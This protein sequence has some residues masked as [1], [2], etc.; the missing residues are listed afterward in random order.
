MFVRDFLSQLVHFPRHLP[1][2]LKEVSAKSKLVNQISFEN[3]HLCLI[4]DSLTPSIEQNTLTC[5]ELL[6]LLNMS[7]QLLGD[8]STIRG[9]II[10]TTF[11]PIYPRGFENSTYLFE[12]PQRSHINIL[13]PI[14]VIKCL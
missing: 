13:K 9:V 4:S 6:R 3:S 2:A 10:S 5:D 11:L 8:Y 7:Y 12:D 1:L 14:L